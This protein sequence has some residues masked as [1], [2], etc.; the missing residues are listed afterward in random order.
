MFDKFLS[1]VRDELVFGL[2]ENTMGK[3]ILRLNMGEEQWKT[4][5]LILIGVPEGR[6]CGKNHG[7]RMA[8]DYIRKELYALTRNPSKAVIGDFGNIISGNA[9][10]DTAI[11]LIEICETL[12]KENIIPLVIGGGISLS[13]AHFKSFQSIVKRLDLSLFTSNFDLETE[14]YLRSI[15]LHEPNFLFNINLL[16]YQSYYVDISSVQALEKM[17]FNPQRLGLIK[18]NIPECEPVLRSSDLVCIDLS[19]VK[20][21]DAPGNFHNNPNGLD[22]SEICQL[23]WYAGVSDMVKS[24]GLYEVNPEFDYRNQTSKLSAQMLWYFI[25]GFANRKGDLPGL[26]NEFVKYRCALSKNQSDVIF[27][28]SKRSQRWWMELPVASKGPPPVLI[29][30]SYADYQ[31]ATKGDMPE[32]FWKALQKISS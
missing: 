18:S 21:S 12:L 19:A 23:S 2:A 28:K 6:E 20:Q 8:P 15:C 7:T 16:A 31:S 27:Y 25:D 26:H 32:R 14:N 1:F 30:C 17:F 4:C 22:S 24:F 13:Y 9:F 10:E 11:A 3:S 5:D 29:P